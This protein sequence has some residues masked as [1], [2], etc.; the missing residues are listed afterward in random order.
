MREAETAQNAAGIDAESKIVSTQRQGA[1]KK[2]DIKVNAELKIFENQRKGDVLESDTALAT[3]KALCD[4]ETKLAN[5]EAKNAVEVRDAELK[6]DLEKK[7][8]K[9]QTEKLRADLLSKAIVDYEIKVII[10]VITCG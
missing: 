7:K 1:A 8:A 6:T 10:H 2:E 9:T 3:K 5:V 4:K